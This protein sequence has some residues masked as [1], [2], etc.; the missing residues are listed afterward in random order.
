M[1][2]ITEIQRDNEG[3]I[4][5]DTM[6]NYAEIYV[7][8]P[9]LTD[10]GHMTWQLLA[11]HSFDRE[12][13]GIQRDSAALKEILP[14]LLNGAKSTKTGEKEFAEIG[15]ADPTFGKL[16]DD[17]ARKALKLTR[18][19]APGDVRGQ[20]ESA[21]I[22]GDGTHLTVNFNQ[23]VEKKSG[24][25]RFLPHRAKSRPVYREETYFGNIESS[26]FRPDDTA[27]TPSND[28]PNG[29]AITPG[30]KPKNGETPGNGNPPIKPSG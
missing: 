13:L 17:F 3:R 12:F 28:D 16:Q 24:F 30:I 5:K 27:R 15:D 7:Y 19:P 25:L 10:D 29:E 11:H 20:K 8:E 9:H 23:P 2:E 4:V 21:P 18:L 6:L 14:T 26:A 1:N 22:S